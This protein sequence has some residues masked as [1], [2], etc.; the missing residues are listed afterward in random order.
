V[1]TWTDDNTLVVTT[2]GTDERTWLNNAGDPHSND[3]KVEERYHRVNRDRLELSVTIDDPKIYTKPWVARDK[4][5]FR[6]MPADTDL[7]EM[8]PSASEA[9]DYKRLMKPDP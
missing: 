8:I 9:A 5:P 4:L 6:L 1:G 7:M 3:L 2:I